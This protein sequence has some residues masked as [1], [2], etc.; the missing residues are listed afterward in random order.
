MFKLE[1]TQW[2]HSSA[3]E[4]R[5][6]VKFCLSC[7]FRHKGG[8]CTDQE[9]KYAKILSFLNHSLLLSHS[10]KTFGA[11]G[12]ETLSHMVSTLSHGCRV[13]V[14]LGPPV[15]T[16]CC[17]THGKEVLTW[18]NAMCLTMFCYIVLCSEHQ[19]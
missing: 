17:R 3:I 13:E 6:N 8:M 14:L 5:L 11:L 12:L 1:E 19:Q 15:G 7:S 4:V 18:D 10:G 16:Y 2:T 9:L